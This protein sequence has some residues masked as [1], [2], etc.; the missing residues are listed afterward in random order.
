MP[1]DEGF[2]TMTYAHFRAQGYWKV[3]TRVP[4]DI[5]DAFLQLLVSDSTKL[6]VYGLYQ[7]NPALVR[8]LF[9]VATLRN[10]LTGILGPNVVL[11]TNRHNVGSRNSTQMQNSRLHRDTL[12]WS[13]GL[14][15]VVIFLQD[16]DVANGCTRVIPGSHLLQSVGVPQAA[17][18]G[19]WM[20]EHEEFREL[21]GQDV[22]VPM[23]AGEVL[24]FDSLLFHGSFPHASNQERPAV[25]FAVRSED[26]L[27]VG[28][29][30]ARNILL[31]GNRLYRGNDR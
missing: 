11:L 26:E 30:G 4:Q 10:V 5:V 19:T 28:H 16:A 25:V 21:A 1:F 17:G 31:Y 22:P 14:L 27:V 8:E 29:D 18:G 6:K 13:R 7:Q 12:Q 15:T 9:A 3:A 23:K 20:D 2:G 24:V